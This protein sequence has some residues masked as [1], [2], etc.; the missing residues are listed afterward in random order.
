M[1]TD[2]H[3]LAAES[4]RH[5]RSRLPAELRS[6]SEPVV[7]LYQDVPDPAVLQQ[8]FE[9]D[10][11]GLF[12]GASRMEADP[13]SSDS[14]PRIILYLENLWNLA[15]G[16]PKIFAE[17]VRTTYLHELGHFLGFDEDDLMMRNL[18]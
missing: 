8:G 6:A 18:D 17:E 13:I 16:D 14:P 4:V 3:R 1:K 10:L 5:I 15:G 2:L 9:P 12:E 11:L 7:T